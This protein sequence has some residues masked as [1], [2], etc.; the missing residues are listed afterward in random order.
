M[1]N[2][3]LGLWDELEAMAL[4]PPTPRPWVEMPALDREQLKS[5]Q[6]ELVGALGELERRSVGG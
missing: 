3:Q 1:N 6:V 2:R 5:L 4:M